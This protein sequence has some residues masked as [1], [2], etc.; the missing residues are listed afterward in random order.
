MRRLRLKSFCLK[1]FF[2]ADDSEFE[3]NTDS[4]EEEIV[5]SYSDSDS[6]FHGETRKIKKRK[7]RGKVGRPPASTSPSKP[8]PRASVTGNADC[9][10]WKVCCTVDYTLII[11]SCL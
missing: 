7:K 3:L 5:E 4:E 11:M 9:S 1:Y 8:R 10:S 6:D 2:A